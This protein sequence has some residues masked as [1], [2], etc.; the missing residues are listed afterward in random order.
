MT[1][2]T[3]DLAVAYRIYPEVSK[4]TIAHSDDKLKLAELSLSSFRMS[5]GEL[6]AK[7][8]I[9]LDGCPPEYKQ[10]FRRYFEEEDLVFVELAGEGNASTFDRQL[11]I[12]LEQAVAPLVYFAEDDYLY[13]PGALEK[14]VHFL[15]GHS[16]VEFVTPYDHLDYYT[17]Q[18]HGS[19]GP[20][21]LYE[22][23]HWR[24][25]AST[26]LTFLTRQETLKETEAVFRT[27]T[28]GRCSDAALWFS[29]TKSSM[30]NPFFWLP[31]ITK[32]RRLFSLF[33][34][35]WR[36]CGLQ[37]LFGRR[38]SL[39]LAIPSLA[40]HLEAECVA[41]AVDWTTVAREAVAGGSGEPPLCTDSR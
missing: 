29:L 39:W 36:R 23:Q 37:L 11:D 13:R 4:L 9:L 35:A 25:A 31:F 20:L 18:I 22:S 19:S 12:L 3:Y 28:S 30:F 40:T 6:R 10:L 7:L 2:G 38:R 5:L 34:Q 41:P 16:D 17:L 24:T 27:Y 8:W 26:C 1:T 21:R 15:G 33:A 32:E 14:M